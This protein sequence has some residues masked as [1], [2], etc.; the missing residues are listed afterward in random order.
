MIFFS[1]H[2]SFFHISIL[3]LTAQLQCKGIKKFYRFVETNEFHVILQH[4][5]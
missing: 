1:F 4:D 2:Q 5:V 3:L